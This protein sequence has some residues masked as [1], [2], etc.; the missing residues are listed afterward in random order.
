MQISN[1]N[2]AFGMNTARLT[3]E[4]VSGKTTKNLK[5]NRLVKMGAD[6]QNVKIKHGLAADTFQKATKGIQNKKA[7]GTEMVTKVFENAISQFAPERTGLDM[8][9][10][11]HLQNL[12]R[13][14]AQ[15]LDRVNMH[16]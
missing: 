14:G 1:I 5:L 3:G 4:V 8:D 12:R 6:S 13:K 16:F 15:I 10:Q 11:P 7:S 2:P 9:I